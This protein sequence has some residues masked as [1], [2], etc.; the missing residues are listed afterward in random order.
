MDDIRFDLDHSLAGKWYIRF[1]LYTYI[2]TVYAEY[3]VLPDNLIYCGTNK[4][5]FRSN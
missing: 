3:V 5:E 2:D 1:S 4:C